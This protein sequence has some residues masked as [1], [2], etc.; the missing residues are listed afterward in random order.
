MIGTTVEP[1]EVDLRA[2][3][4]ADPEG[5][6][7][8]EP[9][10]RA[11]SVDRQA[12]LLGDALTFSVRHTGKQDQEFLATNPVNELKSAQCVADHLGDV[13]KQLIADVVAVEVVDALE[14]VKVEEGDGDRGCGDERLLAQLLE[15]GA[16]LMLPRGFGRSRSLPSYRVMGSLS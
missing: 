1:L 7:D 16:S 15:A 2:V 9:G 14:M 5:G 12:Q 13:P 8:P 4:P 11:Q 3:S 10:R 6:G